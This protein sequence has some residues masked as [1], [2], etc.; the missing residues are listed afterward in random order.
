MP[1]KETPGP[2]T[3]LVVG[4]WGEVEFVML[5]QLFQFIRAPY[6]HSLIPEGRRAFPD[7]SQLN[8]EVVGFHSLS[9][10]IGVSARLCA[11]TLAGAGFNVNCRD[12]GKVFLKKPELAWS[13][14]S[15]IADDRI[16]CRI[17]H[18]TPSMLPR[19]VFSIGRR[20]FESTYNIGYW[21]WETDL[22]PQESQLAVRYI[23]AILVPSRFTRD[24][25]RKYTTKP[26]LLVPHP[27]AVGSVEK[28]IRDMLA[29]GPD[30]FL[31]SFVFSFGS[32]FERK[33]PL[34][35][36]DA[37][38]R[39]FAHVDNAHL[40]LKSSHGRQ[41][42]YE[43]ARLQAAIGL[44][45]RIRLIDDIWPTPR[46]MG[47]IAESNAFVSLHRC[48]GFGLPIAEAI[49]LGVPVVAT[50]WSGNTDFCDP[51]NTCLVPAG[52]TTVDTFHPEFRALEGA[53]WAEPDID[54]AARCLKAI[55]DDPKAAKK[56]AVR[57]KAFMERYLAK[58]TYP[59]AMDELQSAGSTRYAQD[60][61]EA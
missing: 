51:D 21:A 43:L 18:L 19:A 48:E 33:N 22:L 34:A 61:A 4:K 57:A 16:N 54:Q 37:F 12:V 52:E 25:F 42:P 59:S 55:F 26:V 56:R 47:L 41:Y 8:I 11:E 9:V 50:D 23:D 58:H 2:Q 31:A 44:S 60:R 24:V 20:K 1:S 7:R 3:I 10:G 30:D 38:N 36:V 6:L 39:A 17:F 5:R 53:R 49:A 15:R 13:W 35:V 14:R 40:V 28:N 32:S 29:I 27:V 45:P 46:V